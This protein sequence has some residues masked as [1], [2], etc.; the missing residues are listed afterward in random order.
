[1]S[2]GQTEV[3]HLGN[4]IPLLFHHQQIRWLDV[5]MD[6]ALL[7]R[8]LDGLAYGNEQPDSLVHGH[9]LAVAIARDR[10]SVHQLHC[11]IRAALWRGTSIEH[12]RDVRVIHQRQCLSFALEARDHL[13]TVHAR[14]DDFK[15]EVASERV[16]LLRVI[17]H[18]HS[19]FP[20]Q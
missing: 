4:W 16:S 3:D 19:A 11:K 20:K 10:D 1:E 7:M 6:D 2:L 18:A 17:D 8:M 5:A 15:G 12:S 9:A 13:P 14:F